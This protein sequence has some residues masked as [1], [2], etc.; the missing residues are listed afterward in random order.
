MSTDKV[1]INWIEKRSEKRSRIEATLGPNAPPPHTHT[2]T[3]IPYMALFLWNLTLTL[4]FYSFHYSLTSGVPKS[5]A[6][7]LV[8]FYH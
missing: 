1:Q 2:S 3:H 5:G 7:G 4:D 6:G 8:V